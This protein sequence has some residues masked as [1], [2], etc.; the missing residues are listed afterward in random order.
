MALWRRVALFGAR[1]TG[2]RIGVDTATRILECRA[3]LSASRHR[4]RVGTGRG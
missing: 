4:I 3:P 1:L 2:K